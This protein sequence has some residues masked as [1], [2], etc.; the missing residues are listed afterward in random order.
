MYTLAPFPPD[1]CTEG[2]VR[3][4]HGSTARTG[5]VQVCVNRTW[6]SICDSGWSSQDAT[7]VCR[8]LGFPTLGKVNCMRIDCS[9]FIII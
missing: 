8:Q 9:F 6:G 5:T 1:N 3:L 4:M 7:V 2:S